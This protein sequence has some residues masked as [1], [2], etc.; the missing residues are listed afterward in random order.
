[1]MKQ[2]FQTSLR[3][4]SREGGEEGKCKHLLGR[5]ARI[6]GDGAYSRAQPRFGAGWEMGPES[7]AGVE[8]LERAPPAPVN[9]RR[10]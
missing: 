10:A 8:E 4:F 6:H 1:M 3:S 2:A 7:Q 5:S 9:P